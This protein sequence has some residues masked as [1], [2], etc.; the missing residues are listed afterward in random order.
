MTK[1]NVDEVTEDVLNV[2]K[3][4][5]GQTVELNAKS[6]AFQMGQYVDAYKYLYDNWN[7]IEPDTRK[8]HRQQIQDSMISILKGYEGVS[9]MA[10]KQAANAAFEVIIKAVSKLIGLS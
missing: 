6:I 5:L 1:F 2:V 8:L 4:I 9:A 10:A 3:D 7:D